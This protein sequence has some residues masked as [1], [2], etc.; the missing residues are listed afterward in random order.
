MLLL[1]LARKSLTNRLLTT[2]LT[3]LSI[4]FSV[5]LLVGVENVRTG[6]RESFSKLKLQFYSQK[7]VARMQGLLLLITILLICHCI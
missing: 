1:H 4:A 7:R 5:A 6:M 2:S 3:A